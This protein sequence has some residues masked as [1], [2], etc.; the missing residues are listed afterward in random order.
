MS[1]DDLLQMEGRVEEI[2]PNKQYRVRLPN[3][4]LVLVYTSGKMKRKRLQIIIGD[5]VEIE[6]STYDLTKGRLINRL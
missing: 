5:Q 6:M 3:D 2:L 4:H 1:K